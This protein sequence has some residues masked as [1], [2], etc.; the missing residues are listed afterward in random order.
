MT[1]SA[2]LA[3]EIYPTLSA[4]VANQLASRF[5]AL[6]AKSILSTM[7]FPFNNEL[8]F[9]FAVLLVVHYARAKAHQFPEYQILEN[10]FFSF[11]M[12]LCITIGVLLC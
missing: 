3:S 1:I 5:V 6:R 11:V 10:F 7:P 8:V 12:A 9:L 4:M 2:F